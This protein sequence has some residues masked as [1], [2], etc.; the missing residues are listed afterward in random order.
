MQQQGLD[1]GAPANSGTHMKIHPVLAKDGTPSSAFE[2]ENLYISP[3]TI[4]RLLE[5]VDGVTEVQSRGTSFGSSD[6][7]VEFKYRGQPYIVWE[8]YGDSSRYWIGPKD[9]AEAGSGSA[10]LEEVFKRY[11]PPL[12]RA[13]VADVLTL[14]FLTRAFA[15]NR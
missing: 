6:V 15:R 1:A 3:S 5:G 14:R 8:P 9:G 7:R 2:L 11:S 4:A 13:L 12:Y 10:P